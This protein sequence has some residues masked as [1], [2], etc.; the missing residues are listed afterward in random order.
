[1]ITERK[2]RK[3]I[4]TVLVALVF[5]FVS[6]VPASA[7]TKNCSNGKTWS[8]KTDYTTSK[9]AT[10]KIGPSNWDKCN[11]GDIYTAKIYVTNWQTKKVTTYTYRSS[12][13]GA[14]ISITLPNKAFKNYKYSV[15]VDWGKTLVGGWSQ[16]YKAS[17][18]RG[19]F[20]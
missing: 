13:H 6:A 15:R 7:A 16:K 20:F 8:V 5:L 18:T 2:N 4:M 11:A 10:L 19:S 9:S 14:A 1:M 17:V 3:L 12:K